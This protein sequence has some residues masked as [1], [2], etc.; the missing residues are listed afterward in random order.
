MTNRTAFARS[1]I[2]SALASR[3]LT[4]SFQS[5]FFCSFSKK[6]YS[7]SAN[8]DSFSAKVDSFLKILTLFEK[9]APR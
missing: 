1:E 2:A 6:V 5:F 4:R 9:V 7:F 3:S 8:V